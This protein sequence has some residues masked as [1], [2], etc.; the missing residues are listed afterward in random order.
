MDIRYQ[1]GQIYKITDI[2]FNKCYIGST[3][4]PLSNRMS[5][6]RSQ[7]KDYL[8]NVGNV[9]V[10]SFDLFDEYGVENC[11]IV[12]IKDYPCHSKKELEAEEGRIQQETECVNKRMEGRNKK[13]WYKDNID[14]V[15]EK[16]KEYRNNHKD[17]IKVSLKNWKEKNKEQ[18]KERQAQYRIENKEY[19]NDYKKKYYND[20]K[21]NL[22]SKNNEY[23]EKNKDYFKKY[24]EEHKEESK[25][26]LKK[27]YEKN[28]E[29]YSNNR[30][31]KVE[32]CCGA[33]LRKAEISRHYKTKKHQAY[34]QGLPNK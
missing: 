29:Q 24:K 18:V 33:V 11:K 30:K 28:K 14:I 22:L 8:N 23:R 7:Y 4:E 17:E 32:C 15:K 21:E 13:Q 9:K 12:W 27:H 3:I 16:Q 10:K 2:G 31:A 26:Y 5:K 1:K 25:Q 20:N 6:H 34:L 19:L